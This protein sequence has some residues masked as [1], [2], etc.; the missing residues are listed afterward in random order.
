[1]K[2]IAAMISQPSNIYNKTDATAAAAG[3]VV[4]VLAVYCICMIIL[5]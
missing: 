3:G 4:L 2:P 5:W 1:M